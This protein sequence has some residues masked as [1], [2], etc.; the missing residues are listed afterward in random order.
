[1]G[2]HG[3]RLAR[4]GCLEPVAWSRAG[5]TRSEPEKGSLISYCMWEKRASEEGIFGPCFPR[6]L[7]PVEEAFKSLINNN[8]VKILIDFGFLAKC[9]PHA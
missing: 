8:L 7:N 2:R 4:L 9:L 3:P 5:Q 6:F 1:M